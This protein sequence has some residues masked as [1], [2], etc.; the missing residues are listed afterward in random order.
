MNHQ[1]IYGEGKTPA[2]L[3]AILQSMGGRRQQTERQQDRDSSHP[4]AGV[5]VAS[6]VSP[7][8]HAALQALI[9]ADPAAATAL[10]VRKKRGK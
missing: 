10:A 2:Q 1:V 9:Q 6:R 5:I 8:K 7:E 4:A 3:L